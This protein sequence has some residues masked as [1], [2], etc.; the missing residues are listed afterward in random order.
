MKL[1]E[2]FD[3]PLEHSALRPYENGYVAWFY[4]GTR[5]TYVFEA[6]QDSH[7]DPYVI[8]FSLI[9]AQPDRETLIDDPYGDAAWTQIQKE[10]T[11]STQKMTGTGDSVRVIGTIASI[12]KQFVQQIKPRRLS[13]SA[14]IK[15]RGRVLL[16]RRLAGMAGKEL[17]YL[18]E[19]RETEYEF[20]WDLW[21]R[22]KNN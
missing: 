15:D 16:Y 17:G 6:N 12:F 3:R 18:V 8:Y 9:Y 1:T 19:E 22:Y 10:M 4:V 14:K 13:F 5:L 2:L 21:K 20:I 7:T 11:V